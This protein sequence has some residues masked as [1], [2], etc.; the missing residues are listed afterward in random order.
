MHLC[1]SIYT[2]VSWL[3]MLACGPLSGLSLLCITVTRQG[4][5]WLMS[6]LYPWNSFWDWFIL[7]FVGMSLTSAYSLPCHCFSWLIKKDQV[8]VGPESELMY[9]MLH[10]IILVT[11]FLPIGHML[12][13]LHIHLV[14]GSTCLCLV[15]LKWFGSRINTKLDSATIFFGAI[16]MTC[17]KY[18][19]LSLLVEIINVT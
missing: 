5:S 3:L 4:Y 17:H 7:H 18:F 8:T 12:V 14:E 15:F 19:L 1:F 16:E 11:W 2:Y 9:L 6:H 10:R 13:R